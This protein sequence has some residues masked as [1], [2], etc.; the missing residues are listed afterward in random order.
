MTEKS[1]MTAKEREKRRRSL[2]RAATEKIAKSEQLNF[3]L[4]EQSIKALQA[5]SKQKNIPLGTMI[6][7]WVLERLAE[8]RLQ[9]PQLEG[10]ALYILSDLH[11]KLQ[12]LFE[13]I[14]KNS[15]DPNTLQRTTADS[16]PSF[17]VSIPKLEESQFTCEEELDH[18]K[19]WE[20]VLR[21]QLNAIKA[22]RKQIQESA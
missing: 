8:E 14:E 17:M 22:K 2:G 10:Q 12:S 5:L 19:A 7:S 11:S 18:L 21:D 4:E 6:R 20:H 3:R 16:L 13:R 9:K 15:T 1:K